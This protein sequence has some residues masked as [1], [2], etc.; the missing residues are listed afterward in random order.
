MQMNQK[1]AEI[2]LSPP[3]F[4]FPSEHSN[5][6]KKEQPSEQAALLKT[7]HPPSTPQALPRGLGKLRLFCN[8]VLIQVSVSG[9]SLWRGRQF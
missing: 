7:L 5:F 6:A 2:S 1:V 8:S 4:N 3:F 9:P